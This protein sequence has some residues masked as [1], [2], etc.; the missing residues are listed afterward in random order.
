[1]EIASKLG[2][3]VRVHTLIDTPDHLTTES[4]SDLIAIKP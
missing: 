2:V 1:L 3:A 4:T